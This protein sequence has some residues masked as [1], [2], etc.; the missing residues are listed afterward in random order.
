MQ[1]TATALH[2][3]FSRNCALFTTSRKPLR[4]VYLRGG[5]VPELVGVGDLLAQNTGGA[6]HG[7]AAVHALGLREP[8]QLLRIRACGRAEERAGRALGRMFCA[9]SRG[10]TGCKGEVRSGV[11]GTTTAAGEICAGTQFQAAG[12]AVHSSAP[13]TARFAVGKAANAAAAVRHRPM[14][15]KRG[16][17]SAGDSAGAYPGQGDRSRSRRGACVTQKIQLKSL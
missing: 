15:A 9:A 4:A 6:Q 17:D 2:T 11:D 3:G 8:L 7:P 1:P 14:A 5:G 13:A 12:C 10:V 16:C